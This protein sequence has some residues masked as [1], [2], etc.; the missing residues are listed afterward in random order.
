MKAFE[1]DLRRNIDAVIIVGTTL[2]IPIL[3]DFTTKICRRMKLSRGKTHLPG[4]E[5]VV[6]WI[7][8]EK[9]K[10]RAKL[11]DLIDSK[12][13]QDCDEFAVQISPWLEKLKG[14]I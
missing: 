11:R 14:K 4:T 3:E 12:Y 13:L 2:H 8:T 9:P 6:L 10:V 1:E 5:G 7:S